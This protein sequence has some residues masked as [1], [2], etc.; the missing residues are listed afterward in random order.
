MGRCS[1]QV[2]RGVSMIPPCPAAPVSCVTFHWRPAMRDQCTVRV[3]GCCVGLEQ[4]FGLSARRLTAWWRD[5]GRRA[6]GGRE[7]Q[8]AATHGQWMAARGRARWGGGDGGGQRRG[9][10]GGGGRDSWTRAS[11]SSS[12]TTRLSSGGRRRRRARRWQPSRSRG[13]SDSGGG[14]RGGGGA[15]LLCELLQCELLVRIELQGGGQRGQLHVSEMEG[16]ET[17]QSRH[18]H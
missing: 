17:G 8:V 14:R 7:G 3:C 9:R 6:A 2:G 5:G 1:P 15:L 18:V 13:D 4:R 10:R 12:S 11:H 16:G